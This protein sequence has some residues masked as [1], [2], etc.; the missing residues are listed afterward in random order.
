MP[1]SHDDLTPNA[2]AVSIAVS[3]VRFLL[4]FAIGAVGLYVGLII[5]PMESRIKSLEDD[6]EVCT[7]HVI[8]D[9]QIMKEFQRRIE[10]VEASMEYHKTYDHQTYCEKEDLRKVE[11][12]LQELSSALTRHKDFQYYNNGR[13]PAQGGH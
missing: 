3:W 8:K 4:P 13:T 12:E 7:T 9:S 5:A 11:S 1:D 10:T 2:K 6:V